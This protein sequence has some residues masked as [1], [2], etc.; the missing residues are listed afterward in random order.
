MKEELRHEA[1]GVELA[2]LRLRHQ[3]KGKAAAEQRLKLEQTQLELQQIDNF[4]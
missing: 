2:R 1:T 4:L 3:S